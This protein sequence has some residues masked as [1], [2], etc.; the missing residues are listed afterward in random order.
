MWLNITILNVFVFSILLEYGS[1]RFGC[2]T[3]DVRKVMM[4]RINNI[5]KA[6]K[7]KERASQS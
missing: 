2:K 4:S 5:V 3:D 7:A 6:E 1:K